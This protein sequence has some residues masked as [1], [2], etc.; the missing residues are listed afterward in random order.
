MSDRIDKKVKVV[1]DKDSR[2]K[3]EDIAELMELYSYMEHQDRIIERNHSRLE[4]LSKKQQR[5]E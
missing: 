1:M 2:P 3:P 4:E 5:V